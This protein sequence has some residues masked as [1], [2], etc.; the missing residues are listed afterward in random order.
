M[1][2]ES[3]YGTRGGPVQAGRVR[4]LDAQGQHDLRPC[5]EWPGDPLKLPAVPAK[6][7]AGRVLGGGTAE[8]RQS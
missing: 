1:Y 2:G 7:V 4:R 8:V 5:L 6:V 3:I